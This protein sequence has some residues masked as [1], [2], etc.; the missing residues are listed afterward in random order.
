MARL[1]DYR[2]VPAFIDSPNE[3]TGMAKP[4]NGRFIYRLVYVPNIH[5]GE[6]GYWKR[7]GAGAG[8]TIKPY[9]KARGVPF[10]ASPDASFRS[11]LDRFFNPDR[12]FKDH[13]KRIRAAVLAFMDR[14]R[15]IAGVRVKRWANLKAG[16]TI[17]CAWPEEPCPTQ[18]R[19]LGSFEDCIG[20]DYEMSPYL[21]GLA[22]V[23]G[24]PIDP[25]SPPKAVEKREWKSGRMSVADKSKML[26][27]AETQTA[28][29]GTAWQAVGSLYSKG[30]EHQEQQHIADLVRSDVTAQLYKMFC[31]DGRKG[32]KARQW[33]SGKPVTVKLNGA[34]VLVNNKMAGLIRLAQKYTR[35]RARATIGKEWM[36]FR[37]TEFVPESVLAVQDGMLVQ[38]L[39]ETLKGKMRKSRGREL[40][41]EVEYAAF[42]KLRLLCPK[43]KTMEDAERID[44][45]GD[46]KLACGCVRQG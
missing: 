21:L 8:M 18:F 9:L 28:I 27:R 26:S 39:Q 15:A 20:L 29:F 38:S 12:F 44:M 45:L 10:P 37:E 17:V 36:Q 31:S 1:L 30:I 7:P 19:G 5:I 46:Y 6:T 33:K 35:L 40:A 4:K 2:V 3:I 22:D 23:H 13:E 34:D 41:D 43:H 24:K 14:Y 16:P 42:G 32:E 25:S 11:D